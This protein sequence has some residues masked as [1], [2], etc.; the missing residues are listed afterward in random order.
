MYTCPAYKKGVLGSITSINKNTQKPSG[1]DVSIYNAQLNAGS[2]QVIGK[3]S[4]RR[5]LLIQNTSSLNAYLNIDAM[6]GPNNG[7]VIPALSEYKFQTDSIPSGA[8]NMSSDN[9]ADT[10]ASVTIMET[11]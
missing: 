2:T 4:G 9:D 1:S 10:F 11:Y 5:G 3:R 6:A 8:I 7:I